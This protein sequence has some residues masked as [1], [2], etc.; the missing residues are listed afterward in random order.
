MSKEVS[1]YKFKCMYTW[2]PNFPAESQTL[3]MTC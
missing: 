1:V 3:H 2:L